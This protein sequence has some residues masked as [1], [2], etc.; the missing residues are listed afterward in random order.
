M[1]EGWSAGMWKGRKRKDEGVRERRRNEKRG[2]GQGS[3]EGGKD[4]REGERQGG[5]KLRVDGGRE[6]GCERGSVWEGGK[7][8]GNTADVGPRTRS[9]RYQDEPDT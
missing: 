2:R 4:C 5:R 3:W 6:A 8:E 9:W 1:R 7:G